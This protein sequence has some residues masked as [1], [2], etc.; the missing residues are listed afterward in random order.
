MV[1]I[2]YIYAMSAHPEP[3]MKSVLYERQPTAAGGTWAS[4]LW[5]KTLA[6]PDHPSEPNGGS[7][8]FLALQL[9]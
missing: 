1:R 2:I 9:P 5:L 8:A 3:V 6:D 4:R 7:N